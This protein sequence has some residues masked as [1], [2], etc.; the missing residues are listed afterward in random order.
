MMKKL[1]VQASTGVIF[2]VKLQYCH[3]TLMSRTFDTFMCHPQ[4]NL[5][6]KK[7]TTS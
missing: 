7:Q 2:D 5:K 6:Q 1:N 4:E 3:E